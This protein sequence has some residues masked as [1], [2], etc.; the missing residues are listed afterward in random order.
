VQMTYRGINNVSISR[1]GSLEVDTSFGKLRE[2]KPLLYQQI[3]GK[4]IAVDGH[5]KLTTSKSYT[6][7]VGTH[8]T[9]YPL[10]IDPTLLYSTFLGGS[11]GVS[12]TNVSVAVD[13][14]GN[15][16]VTGFT[17]SKDFPTT[18]GSFQPIVNEGVDTAFVTKLNA[19][20]TSL[21]YSTYIGNN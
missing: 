13:V 16:Y 6:F 20:G 8:N 17:V 19:T 21:V 9:E 14:A 11:A 15:A 1:D 2:T 18:P 7:E 4:R 3:A 12:S 5:F 10:V